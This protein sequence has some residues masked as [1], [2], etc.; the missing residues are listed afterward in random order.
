M[1]ENKKKEYL[2]LNENGSCELR[3]RRVRLSYPSLFTPSRI[4]TMPDSK[5]AYRAA[6]LLEG[7]DPMNLKNAK[8]AYEHVAKVCYKKG[9]PKK[10]EDKTPRNPEKVFLRSCDL[11][12]GKD[13]YN[14]GEFFISASASAER[15][16]AKLP[17]P[18]VVDNKLLP[19]GTLRHLEA[20]DNRI[21]AGC[22]V[23]VNLTIKA[24][25]E[26]GTISAYINA[27]QFAADGEPFGA[28]RVNAESEFSD[29]LE[30]CEN[31]GESV[32]V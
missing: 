24:S 15:N 12:A 14:E 31:E 8:A 27:V 17:H 1:N 28:G 21:Y 22:Y 4:P 20:E 6:F 16:G 3:L 19:D 11:K 2:V 30:E 26:F 23:N 13:G 9:S 10:G 18:L 5:L 29:T 32:D 25:M 7:S